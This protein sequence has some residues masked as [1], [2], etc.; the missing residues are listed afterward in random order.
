[1][2]RIYKIVEDRLLL[3]FIGAI[4][5]IVSGLCAGFVIKDIGSAINKEIFVDSFFL[6]KVI[7]LS[8]LS[9][10]LGVM[11]SYFTAKISAII[12]RKLTKSLSDK[13]LQA[14]FEYVEANSEKIV[15]ILTRDIGTLTKIVNNTPQFLISFTTLI[16][17][18]VN[19]FISA[20][21]LTLMFSAIFLAQ[22]IITYATLPYLKRN[23]KKNIVLNNS[24]FKDL[25]NLV[26]GL[27]ELSLNKLRREKY[28][29]RVIS[30][31]I[32]KLNA[33]QIQRK[34]V[35][36]LSERI[37]TLLTFIFISILMLYATNDPKIDFDSLTLF[38][39][40]ILFLLPFTVRISGYIKSLNSADAALNQIHKFGIDVDSQ[41]VNLA[42]RKIHIDEKENLLLNFQGISFEYQNNAK[43][44]NKL[45]FGPLN[46]SIQ[47][48]KITFI[49]GGNGSGKTT[50]SKILTGL[51]IPT[52][53][54][55]KVQNHTLINDENLL[56]YRDLFSAYYADSHVFEYL[57]HIDSLFLDE[58]SQ[59]FI[60]LLEMNEK[61]KVFN[62]QFTTTKLSYGQ[63]CRLAL[64]ANL[65]DNKHIYLFDEWAANQDPHFKSIFYYN[66]LP[67]LKENGKTVIVISHDEKYFDVGDEV[68]KLKEGMKVD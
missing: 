40:S 7:L 34:V 38:L 30:S 44:E 20:P 43:F 3:F 35:L 1:M 47:K 37:S 32:E 4:T 50:F 27:K 48:N 36:S 55:I 26:L 51:Y 16:Y 28:V 65:L 45:T 9:A 2:F 53:G 18:L 11:S 22:A 8:I 25:S 57:D 6:K 46:L 68:I 42:Q 5:G 49:V 56:A 19:L 54:D 59:K 60:D 21:Y 39:P 12:T 67:Y 58:N 13:I 29:G 24:V 63:R 15:P 31:D 33:S 14:K 66:I 62:Q 41:K 23:A 61:V 64:I 17:T 52:E 10:I